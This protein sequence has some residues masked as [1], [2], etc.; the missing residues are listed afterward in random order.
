MLSEGQSSRKSEDDGE[1]Q[2]C[3]VCCAEYPMKDFISL[4]CDHYFCPMCTFGHLE[5]QIMGRE[6]K[7]KCMQEG[8]A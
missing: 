3:G 6:I 7:I 4:K 5:T 8:C 2:M 1:R